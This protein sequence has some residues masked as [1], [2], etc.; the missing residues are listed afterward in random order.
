MSLQAI[1]TKL[2]EAHSLLE[3]FISEMEDEDE[4]FESLEDI[5]NAISEHLDQ[6]AGILEEHSKS[7]E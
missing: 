3:T 1:Q 2:S 6:L 7:K 5:K 4:H